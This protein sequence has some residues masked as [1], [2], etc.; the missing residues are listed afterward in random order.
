MDF[1][2]AMSII[3]AIT[4]VAMAYVYS[5]RNDTRAAERERDD[6]HAKWLE[7]DRARRNEMLTNKDLRALIDAL[8]GGG[9]YR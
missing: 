6:Y 8:R 5:A 7:A 4:W 1:S 3:G 2:A 9:P